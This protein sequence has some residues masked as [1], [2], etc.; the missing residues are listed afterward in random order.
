MLFL[1]AEWKTNDEIWFSVKSFDLKNHFALAIDLKAAMFA[2][3]KRVWREVKHSNIASQSLQLSCKNQLK[4]KQ[5]LEN[6]FLS[7]LIK[8]LFCL[9]Q[10]TNDIQNARLI[11]FR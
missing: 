1:F 3:A 8:K 10:I 5:M 11:F 6:L 9:P 7:F 4:K 2:K